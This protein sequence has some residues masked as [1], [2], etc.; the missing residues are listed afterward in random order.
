[1]KLKTQSS[2][3]ARRPLIKAAKGMV[4]MTF[5]GGCRLWYVPPTGGEGAY[6]GGGSGGNGGG[7]NGGGGSGGDV[8]WGGGGN[9]G[10]GGVGGDPTCAMGCAEA[11]T[12]NLPLCETASQ[13]SQDIYYALGDCV[14][15][16]LSTDAIPGC[17]DPILCGN[18]VCMGLYASMDC[19][20]CMQT[21]CQK[22]Y[23]A[24]AVDVP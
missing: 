8:S 9:G 3:N 22:E 12:I 21:T 23:A 7:G 13:T 20:N 4:A 24:C 11:V 17:A 6:G 18:N 15:V 5:L 2:R 16:R 14:C 19:N 1:M 10:N